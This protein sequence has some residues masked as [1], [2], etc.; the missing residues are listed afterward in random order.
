MTEYW[1]AA[2]T[3]EFAPSQMLEQSVAAERAGFDALG[4]SDHF[5]P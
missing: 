5:A 4:S 1:F 3:E 2:S